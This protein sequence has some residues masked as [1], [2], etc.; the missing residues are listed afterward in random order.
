MTYKHK[1]FMLMYNFLSQLC[2]L[3]FLTYTYTLVYNIYYKYEYIT[4]YIA[5]FKSCFVLCIFS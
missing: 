3:N 5:L 1:L 2:Y 4:L